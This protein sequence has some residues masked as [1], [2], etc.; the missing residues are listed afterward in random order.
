MT[1]ITLGDIL[2]RA[3]DFERRLEGLYADLRDRVTRDPQHP[4]TRALLDAVPVPDPLA[5]GGKLSLGGEM[6]SIINPPL[7]CVFHPR[8]RFAETRCRVQLP[9]ARSVGGARV[10]C[11]RAEELEL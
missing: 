1:T 8:C 4:Y 7:G 9:R 2:D 3:L 6:P 10:A 5:P 11:H